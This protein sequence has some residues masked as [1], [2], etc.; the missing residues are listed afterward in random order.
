MGHVVSILSQQPFHGSVSLVVRK[1][2]FWSGSQ[3][4][5]VVALLTVTPSDSLGDCVLLPPG[6]LGYAGLDVRAPPGTIASLS[7]NTHPGL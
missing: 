7:L 5:K 3:R 2:V 4:E 1:L 6:S